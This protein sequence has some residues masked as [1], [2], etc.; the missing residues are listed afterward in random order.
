MKLSVNQ[1]SVKQTNQALII[2]YIRQ[3]GPTSRAGLAKAL[4]M[5]KPAVSANVEDLLNREVLLERGAGQ[6]SGGR[7]PTLIAF[8][9]NYRHIL[10]L[11]L[12]RNHP[13]ICLVNLEGEILHKH[14]ILV[15]QGDLKADLEE[16][17]IRQV[18]D[19]LALEPDQCLGVITLALPGV[20]DEKTGQVFANPQFNHW[21][22]LNLKDLFESTYPVD[23]IM[24]NDI[25]MAALGEKHF[26]C[27]QTVEDLV[28]VSLG[29]GLGA[30]IILNN[31]LHEGKRKAAGEIGF[32]RIFS[33]N[34]NLEDYLS[35]GAVYKRIEKDI[36]A[37]QKTLLESLEGQVSLETIKRALDQGDSY[38]QDLIEDMG[39]HLG[40]AIANMAL[41]LD[42]DLI[43]IGGAIADLGPKFVEGIRGVVE[44]I[45]P[46]ET[47]ISLGDLG[48]MSGTYG[49]INL[50]QIS[51]LKGM[52]I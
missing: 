9:K 11:D 3:G 32:S 43:I 28:Y 42:L 12:N 45:V 7:I 23:V 51:I 13:Q 19:L 40:T 21:K 4:A 15:D 47:N 18:D 48:A 34:D 20:I 37:G 17:I 36:Q 31:R 49:L 6:S 10:T 22:E 1:S 44:E 8:N 38:C 2:D 14:E 27:G 41:L 16:K 39:K 46:F 35:L 30:G 25:D 50:G 33:Q 26:G 24:K 5:S 29:M 52:V